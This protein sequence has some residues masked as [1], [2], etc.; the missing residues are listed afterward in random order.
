MT[1]LL[2]LFLILLAKI[3]STMISRNGDNGYF[4]LISKLGLW[5]ILLIFY[6]CICMSVSENKYINMHIYNVCHMS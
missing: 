4:C 6:K 2:F 3:T 1:V 5:G